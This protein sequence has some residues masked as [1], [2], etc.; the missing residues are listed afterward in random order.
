MSLRSEIHQQPETLRALLDAGW[1][2]VERAAAAIRAR[3]IDYI[4]LAARG[5]SEHAGIYGQY[6][7]GAF[8]GLPVAL[9]APSLFGV[10]HRP[11]RLGRALVVGVSQSGQ[12]PDIVGV[13]DEA[14][15]Q[16]ALTLS[17]TNDPGSPLAQAA[18]ISLDIRAG[19]ER[20]VAATKTY[21]AQLLT[22]AMLSV[23]LAGDADRRADLGRLPAAVAA[24][25]QIEDDVARAA[26]GLREMGHC[27]VLGRGYH[28][29]TA[30]EWSLKLKELTYVVAERYSTAEFQHGPIA[31]VEPG[32]PVLAVAPRDAGADDT[33][34]LLAR[35]SGERGA[36]VLALSDD[37]ATLAA[38]TVG[39]RLP[40][41]LPAWLAPIISIAPAQLFCYH[42]ALA[43]GFDPDA[44]RGLSKVTRTQ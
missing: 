28:F 4:Y 18:A 1:A 6:V 23:A 37:E 9:A 35:L 22:F 29:A 36:T 38:A 25:L 24:A 41:G 40:G 16:G 5:T 11:P 7:L 21:S 20:A 39:L 32:F 43:R 13:L 26:A 2:D 30:L 19:S 42:L 3:E 34:A 44:P 17:I 10:Y 14:N 12:S 27:V 31:L 15:R 8:N 33:R